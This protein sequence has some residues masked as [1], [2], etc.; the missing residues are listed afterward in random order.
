VNVHGVQIVVAFSLLWHWK[1]RG[2]KGAQTP[3]YLSIRLKAS[4]YHKDP[5]CTIIT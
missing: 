4:Q 1:T 5:I 2:V 3:S